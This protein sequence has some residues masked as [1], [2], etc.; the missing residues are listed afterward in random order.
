M[1]SVTILIGIRWSHFDSLAMLNM[2][3]NVAVI[4]LGGYHK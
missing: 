2:A 4:F 3:V 1:D